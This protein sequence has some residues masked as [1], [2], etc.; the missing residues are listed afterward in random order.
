MKKTKLK[1]C[2]H[3][4]DYRGKTPNKS[5]DGYILI[6]AKNVKDYGFSLEPREYIPKEN[7]ESVMVRGIPKAGDILFTTEAPLGNVCRIPDLKAPFAVGQRIIVIRPKEELLRSDYV[8]YVLKS[9]R[10]R[11]EMWKR[12]S[13]STVKGIRSKELVEIEIPIPDISKQKL[14]AGSLNKINNIIKVRQ[15]QLTDLDNL[16]KSRFVEM[17]GD[18]VSNPK[19]LPKIPLGELSVL[20][21]K[22]ASPKWQGIGYVEDESQTLFVTSENVREGY[23]DLEKTKYLQDEF[24]NKQKRSVLNKGD[25][26]I[27]IVGASIG[28]AAQFNM[29]V[30]ANINQAVALVRLK[31]SVVNGKYLLIYL[32]SSKALQMYT[33]MQVSV[34]RANLSLQ[35]ISD[36]EILLPPL[37]L[38][39]QFAT[40]VQQ[41]D[42][43]KVRVQ[44]SL[45]ET[46]LLFDSLMQKYFG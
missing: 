3:F 32:N 1:S 33:E 26:L 23:L 19:K 14:I 18:P 39:N 13:G 37:N 11:D 46:Q 8:E 2:C 34:A 15:M 5:E 38:Q 28:R 42:K 21:T 10:F 44:E 29:D 4:I 31:E 9:R 20:I 27:N 16:V 45:N 40:F 7:Y 17:F 35:N 41:V 12:S 22:G 30:K 24:N 6:T 43:L 25:F 36:L